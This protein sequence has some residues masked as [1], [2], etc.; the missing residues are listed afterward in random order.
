MP[1]LDQN[2]VDE[3]TFRLEKYLSDKGHYLAPHL[4]NIGRVGRNF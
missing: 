4:S 1:A 2:I 3:L